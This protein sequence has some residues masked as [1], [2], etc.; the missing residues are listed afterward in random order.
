MN[1]KRAILSG[2]VE[3]EICE[4]NE[5]LR[6]YVSTGQL[7]EVLDQP[8]AGTEVTI[9]GVGEG[10]WVLISRATCPSSAVDK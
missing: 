2:V 8:L 5:A 4:W 9:Q 7:I 1:V 6:Q 10:K 3:A